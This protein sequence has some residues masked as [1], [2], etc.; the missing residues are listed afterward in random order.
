MAGTGLTWDDRQTQQQ[1]GGMTRRLA[2]MTQVMRVAGEVF[3]HVRGDEPITDV[4]RELLEVCF[5]LARRESHPDTRLGRRSF[6]DFLFAVRSVEF[7]QR[8][9]PRWQR[10]A[11]SRPI[12][13]P[14]HFSAKRDARSLARR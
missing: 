5:P 9:P 13:L 10:C 14:H 8:L 6:S 2:N 1:L 3:L 12:R 4:L 7:V 11:A